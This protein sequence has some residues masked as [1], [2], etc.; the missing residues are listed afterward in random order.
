MSVSA[1]DTSADT[2]VP[3]VEV[4][5]L[6]KRYGTV[7]A[8]R[9]IDLTIRQG[10]RFALLGPNGAGKTTLFSI[11]ATLRS[12]SG[13]SARVLGHDVVRERDAVR[14]SMGIVFQE[15]AIE[16]KLTGRDNLLLMGLFYGLAPGEARRRAAELLASLRLDDAAD[17][18]TEKL[19]GGQRRKLELARA[20]V[21]NPRILFLD[22]ATLG[23]D[24][25]ARR[26]F[27][28]HVGTLAAAG[29]T[30]FFTTHYMEEA[31]VADRIALISSGRIIA[32]D[33]PR[34]LKARLGGG[35]ISLQT[36]DDVR[37]REWLA[38]RGFT[39]EPGGPE[40]R[41]VHLDPASILPELLKNLPV[42]VQ[43]VE[44]HAPSLEDVFL[45]LTG[46]GLA[47]GGG[48]A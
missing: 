18:A 38:G 8:L 10:E 15:P 48:G 36:D 24:V 33:T 37:A 39:P 28:S 41:L 5:G 2:Q 11:L 3:A 42:T 34:A 1:A 47:A 25:D 7:E 12:P 20:L 26:S 23:L 4:A 27:W 31:E 14:R 30:V 43:R 16:R 13:G 22:E 9:G 45:K 46:R 29:R 17:R 6:E 32:L 21:T 19:S 40:L 44:V 35:V